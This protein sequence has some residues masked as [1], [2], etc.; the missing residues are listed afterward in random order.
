MK[1]NNELVLNSS[2][3]LE[4]DGGLCYLKSVNTT[5]FLKLKF[6]LLSDTHCYSLLQ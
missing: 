5:K 4:A 2:V 6:R 1:T 3:M